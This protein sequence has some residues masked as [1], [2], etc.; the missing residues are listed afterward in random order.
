MKPM[1]IPIIH[2]DFIRRD[3]TPLKRSAPMTSSR[4]I[5]VLAALL[6]LLL[7]PSHAAAQRDELARLMRARE[8]AYQ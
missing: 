2:T 8:V 7:W 6:C 5:G 3:P 4:S 1:A